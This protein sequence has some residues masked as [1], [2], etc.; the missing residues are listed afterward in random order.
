MEMNPERTETKLHVLDI[1]SNTHTYIC[2]YM[3]ICIFIELSVKALNLNV[4]WDRTEVG[5]FAFGDRTEAKVWWL[6]QFVAFMN[7]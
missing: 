4:M 7:D 6:H 2:M 3:Y 1:L 5:D